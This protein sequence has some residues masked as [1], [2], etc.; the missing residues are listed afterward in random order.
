MVSKAS[1]Q[2]P[3]AANDTLPPAPE[4]APEAAPAAAAATAVDQDSLDVKALAKGVLARDFRPKVSTVRR[5]AEAVLA[6]SAETGKKKKK[7]KASASGKS[8]GKKR[9]LARIP[10]QKD[11]K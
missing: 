10:G 8:G 5:L 11:K 6:K 2:A 7:K 3:H 9:K 4:A 1:T